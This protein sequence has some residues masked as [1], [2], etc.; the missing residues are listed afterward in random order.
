MQRMSAEH[1]SVPSPRESD[2]QRNLGG[3]QRASDARSAVMAA[4]NVRRTKRREYATP[5]GCAF[6]AHRRVSAEI[7]REPMSW[8]VG[9]PRGCPAGWSWT[10]WSTLNKGRSL[11][12]TFSQA[13]AMSWSTLS[14]SACIAAVDWCRTAVT[15]SQLQAFAIPTNSANIH[16]A[17]TLAVRNS[18]WRCRRRGMTSSIRAFLPARVGGVRNSVCLGPVELSMKLEPITE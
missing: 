9:R 5:G 1:G 17:S 2:A 15:P 14:L 8:D 4:Y 6:R 16:I 18:R 12:P 11:L 3:R 13:G 7:G 10:S